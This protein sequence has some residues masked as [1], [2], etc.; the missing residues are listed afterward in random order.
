MLVRIIVKN[1]GSF[2]EP[3]EFN[4]LPSSRQ[5]NHKHHIYDREGFSILKMS[6]IYGANGAGK[7]NLSRVLHAI[8][9]FITVGKLGGY[10]YNHRHKFMDK[11]ETQAFVIEIIHD[12]VPFLYGFEVAGKEIISEELYKSSFGKG[13]NELVLKRTKKDGKHQLELPSAFFKNGEN[14][15]LHKVIEKNLLKKD[16]SALKTLLDLEN[17]EFAEVDSFTQFFKNCLGI[18]RPHSKPR[19]LALRLESEEEFKDYVIQMM[20]SFGIGIEDVETET[21][22][23]IE[24]T[25]MVDGENIDSIKEFIKEFKEDSNENKVMQVRG[26]NSEEI[27]F[28]KENDD[29]VVK[30]MIFKH[31]CKGSVSKLFN[32]NE[33]SDGTVRLLDYMPLFYDVVRNS[34]VYF[35]DEIE[36]SIHPLLV[37]QLIKKFADDVDTRGQLVFTTHETNLLDQQILRTD[38][39]WFLEK[40]LEGRTQMYPLSDFKE[41]HSKNI[42]KGYLNGRYGAIP[43]LGNLE[44]LN[45][46]THAIA[47]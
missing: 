46:N 28:V 15:S 27:L 22:S 41:H 32:L 10:I 35:V 47:Q 30:R 24:M 21:I 36:R 43:F 33:E 2:G 40:D 19:G 39:V 16:I 13:E 37:K 5:T 3:T 42:Q 4:L 1:F 18:I 29:V 6:A 31:K 34:K 17:E 44:D 20:Q 45:W 25:D 26:P 12:S 7:S 23:L 38:E 8:R 9:R 14:A 11:E